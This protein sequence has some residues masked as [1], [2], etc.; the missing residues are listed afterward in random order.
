M[1]RVKAKECFVEPSENEGYEQCRFQM[2]TATWRRL[3]TEAPMLIP[4]VYNWKKECNVSVSWGEGEMS[5]N[6]YCAQFDL[7]EPSMIVH[8]PWRDD[9]LEEQTRTISHGGPQSP[10]S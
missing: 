10:E 1:G 4:R 3:R 8:R 2:F 6:R 9:I 5:K 7:H